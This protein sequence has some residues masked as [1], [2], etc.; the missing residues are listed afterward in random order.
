LEYFLRC[1]SSIRSAILCSVSVDIWWCRTV[2]KKKNKNP[3]L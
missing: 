2:K 1:S 3:I